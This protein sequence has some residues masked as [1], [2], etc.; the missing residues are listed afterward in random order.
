MRIAVIGAG[1]GGLAAAVGLQRDGHDVTVYEKQ[2]HL[3][4]LGAGLT[5]FGNAFKALDLLGL[6]DTVRGVSSDTVAS[7]RAGQR[8]P[9]GRWLLKAPRS[10]FTSMRSVHHTDL[11]RVLVDAL[12]SGSLLL[13]NSAVTSAD[14][15]PEVTVETAAGSSRTEE[16]DLVIAADGI[17]SRNRLQLGLDTGLHYTGYTAWRG[18]TAHPIDLRGEA[19]EAWGR[20]QLF[21]VVPLPDGRI[22]W[23]GTLKCSASGEF[24]DEKEAV[25][26]FFHG[27]HEPIQE[28][29]AATPRDQVLRHD[30]HDLASPLESFTRG[31]TVLLGDAAHAMTPNLGQGAGQGIED[32]A[33]LVLLLRG[34]PATHLHDELR[35]YSELR[36]VRTTEIWRSSRLTGR[37]AQASNPLLIGLRNAALRVTPGAALGFMTQRLQNWPVPNDRS[38]LGH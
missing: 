14:G 31:E 33:T 15:S 12:D 13:G 7:L 19:G 34:L 29:I 23:F 4:P 27:W 36:Q 8:T 5:L 38:D 35:R 2:A 17:R 1:I 24:S 28:C 21:G 11:H 25:S 3:E 9:S 18:V 37:V 30:L 10:A 20:G 26:R 6:G 22:Y 16:F 32:A